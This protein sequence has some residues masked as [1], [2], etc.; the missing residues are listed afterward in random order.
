M[1]RQVMN[2][3]EK[4][5]K[6][7]LS[8]AEENIKR[9]VDKEASFMYASTVLFPETFIH[10]EELRGRSRAEAEALF[11]HVE[12]EEEEREALRKEIRE[13]AKNLQQQEEMRRE[14]KKAS[15]HSEKIENTMNRKFGREKESETQRKDIKG[16]AKKK[17][18][19]K[20]NDKEREALRKEMIEAARKKEQESDSEE[21]WVDH[22]DIE[23]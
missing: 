9:V 14:A 16:G 12:V 19:V 8:A 5:F 17:E 10:R 21:D 18:Q 11:L 23:E 15:K 20:E 13:E 3:L 1:D 6:K 2:R 22:S 7:N 4:V